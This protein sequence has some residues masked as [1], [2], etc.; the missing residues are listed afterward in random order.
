METGAMTLNE[1]SL[2][3]MLRTRSFPVKPS[4]RWTSAR[5]LCEQG[6]ATLTP[7][8]QVTIT[9]KGILEIQS[10]TTSYCPGPLRDVQ[11]Q[12]G[13]NERSGDEQPGRRS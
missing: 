9:L 7:N 1:R 5:R 12:G 3:Q 8:Q 11:L 2:L 10:N 6:F 13:G 4:D